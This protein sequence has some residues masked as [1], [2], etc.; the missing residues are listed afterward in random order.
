MLGF[1]LIMQNGIPSYR[2]HSWRQQERD[3]MDR[4][5]RLAAV[6][7][8]KWGTILDFQ[9]ALAVAVGEQLRGVWRMRFSKVGVVFHIAARQQRQEEDPDRHEHCNAFHTAK[10]GNKF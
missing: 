6:A 4:D 1:K 3:R 5:G 2:L 10:V 8:A 7:M 9:S